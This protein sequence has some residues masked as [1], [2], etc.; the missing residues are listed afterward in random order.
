MKPDTRCHVDTCDI[1]ES[2]QCLFLEHLETLRPLW[3]IALGYAEWR[4]TVP[5]GGTSVG[6]EDPSVLLMQCFFK[7]SST[8]GM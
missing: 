6:E 5:I 3:L 4:G 7:M 1:S 8:D 2:F